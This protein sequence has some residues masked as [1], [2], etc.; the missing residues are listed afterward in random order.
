MHPVPHLLR[1]GIA[2]YQFETIHPFLDGNGR[3]GRLLIALYVV[4]TGLL[5]KPALYLSAYFDAHRQLYYDNLSRARTHND[6]AQWLRFFLAGIR[7]T[8]E[9]S[10]ATFKS[11]ITLRER[12]ER[13]IATLGKKAPLAQS[14]LQ[15]LYGKP[16]VDGQEVATS[17]NIN[18]STALRL[19]ADFVRLGILRERTGFKRNRLFV[20][21]DYVALFT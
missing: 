9:G 8:S 7:Q 2:H 1:I 10:I 20:F 5:A 3:I 4:S 14:A 17:L 12:C 6:L 18:I 13:D 19:I 21:H 15:L 16:I 11:I